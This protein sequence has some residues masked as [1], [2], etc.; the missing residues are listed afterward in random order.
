[1]IALIPSKRDSSNDL[2]PNCFIA[3]LRLHRES[4]LQCMTVQGVRPEGGM[5]FLQTENN[6]REAREENDM[7]PGDLE[8]TRY[9]SLS[10]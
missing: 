7:K 2:L 9:C 8:L 1:M 5:A 6:R 10:A 4:N 3:F